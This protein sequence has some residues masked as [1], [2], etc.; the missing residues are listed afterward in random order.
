MNKISFIVQNEPAFYN[1]YTSKIA[2][3]KYACFVLFF[4]VLDIFHNR[5]ICIIDRRQNKEQHIGVTTFWFSFTTD[6][7]Y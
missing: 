3:F 7:V 4:H 1:L 5:V 6:L 2:F